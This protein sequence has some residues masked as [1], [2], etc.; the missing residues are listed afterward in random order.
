M[1]A[2]SAR[3]RS[4]TSAGP[5][6]SHGSHAEI[7]IPY[8]RSP[9]FLRDDVAC[10]SHGNSAVDVAQAEIL[11]AIR[12]GGVTLQDLAH[13]VVRS[14]RAPDVVTARDRL[15]AAYMKPANHIGLAAL[16][17][18]SHY[19]FVLID[20]GY[21]GVYVHTVELWKKLRR[22]WRS[23]LIAP[24]EPLFEGRHHDDVLTLERLREHN[25]AFS[26]FSFI[27]LVRAVLQLLTCRLLLV[28]H[29]SQSLY[30]FDLMERQPSIVY[31][32]GYYDS[33]FR[34]ARDCRFQLDDES[35]AAITD[36]MF[37]V[38]AN[39]NPDFYGMEASPAIN[40]Q[41]LQAG[42]FALENAS[43][44]W[45][46]GKQQTRV[47]Q[48]TFPDF[49]KRIRFVPPFINSQL[50]SRERVHRSPVVLFTTTMHNIEKK[51]LP[52]LVKAARRMPKLI[53][54]CVVRQPDL[55]P[56][57][58][59]SVRRRM[60][61]RTLKKPEMV[62]RYH[63]VWLN[64]RTSREESSPLSILEAMSCEV[65]QIVSP[66][67]AEQIPLLEDGRTG[68][69]IDPDDTGALVDALK[70]V[71]SDRKLRDR[72]GRECRERVLDYSFEQR[73]QEFERFL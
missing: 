23:L 14:G 24:V 43:E 55:L 58:P 19:D 39:G 51:G 6:G 32:D 35:R 40:I 45:C 4:A 42:W 10:H 49:K 60:N 41:V 71:L 47:M 38:L 8:L 69:V 22:R 17:L 61:V 2:E 33:R 27:H 52:E 5:K 66:T 72:L 11:D 68:F 57:I 7:E 56:D 16:N 21:G 20:Q 48:D 65:P 53:V 73:Q 1:G 9:V 3:P 59:P 54:D 18:R 26:Y 28:S 15:S 31:C 67:V 63:E 30:Y 34:L 37:Y 12:R 29:R 25:K 13:L 62:Q 36:E 50:F 70:Q 64:C 44:N 46:W